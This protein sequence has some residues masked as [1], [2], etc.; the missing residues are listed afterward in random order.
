MRHNYTEFRENN[1]NLHLHGTLHITFCIKWLNFEVSDRQSYVTSR[2]SLLKVGGAWA[3]HLIGNTWYIK[4]QVKLC[5]KVGPGRGGAGMVGGAGTLLADTICTA[6]RREISAWIQTEFSFLD[7]KDRIPNG[8]KEMLQLFV[9]NSTLLLSPSYFFWNLFFQINL[10]SPI[11]WILLNFFYWQ[12]V[13]PPVLGMFSGQE[14][15]TPKTAKISLNL[16][17]AYSIETLQR[18]EI[19]FQWCDW[20]LYKQNFSPLEHPENFLIKR[21]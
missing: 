7:P 5:W 16:V 11:V 6:L 12:M 10:G 21:K 2:R 19:S 4:V 14:G 9:L 20:Y 15:T 8:G 3:E 18:K 13:A 1:N 17:P